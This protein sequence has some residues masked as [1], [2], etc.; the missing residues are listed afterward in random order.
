MAKLGS[1]R[2]KGK[3]H[4]SCARN[5]SASGIPGF[6]WCP[7][8]YHCVTQNGE[9]ASKRKQDELRAQRFL[10]QVAKLEH[11]TKMQVEFVWRIWARLA[12]VRAH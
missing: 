12:G 4:A 7:A 6:V 1:D 5:K 11:D 10:L 3:S 8:Q 9:K 2:N